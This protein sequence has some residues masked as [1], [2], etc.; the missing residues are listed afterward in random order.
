MKVC[1][2]QRHSKFTGKHTVWHA[3][4]WV[5]RPSWP[6]GSPCCNVADIQRRGP[7]RLRDL[8]CCLLQTEL[9]AALK[10]MQQMQEEQEE[11]R[12]QA[13]DAMAVAE[14]QHGLELQ[15][16]NVERSKLQVGGAGVLRVLFAD[17]PID[18][19]MLAW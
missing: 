8:R 9:D 18:T 14:E 6:H 3:G 4:D 16:L 13:A 15:R 17:M 11:Q 10:Q 1:C 5:L 12:K 7:V 19:C 2:C